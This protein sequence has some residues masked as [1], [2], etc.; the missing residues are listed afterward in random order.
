MPKQTFIQRKHRDGQQAH[1]KYS[2][3]LNH[4]IKANKNQ[5]EML[6]HNC[7]NVYCQK[8]HK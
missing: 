2:T 5:K 3:S 7:L 4:Q 8:D 1:A 6:L